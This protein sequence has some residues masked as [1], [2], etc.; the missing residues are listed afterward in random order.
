MAKKKRKVKIVKFTSLAGI[1][2]GFYVPSKES[3]Y[4][5]P[6][7]YKL[8]GDSYELMRE[9]LTVHQMPTN[10]DG[11]NKFDTIEKWVCDLIERN[12]D[13]FTPDFHKKVSEEKEE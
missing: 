11:S 9:H 12:V 10:E 13:I 8:I 5:S 6:D 1:K 4:V 7:V 3:V 2:I